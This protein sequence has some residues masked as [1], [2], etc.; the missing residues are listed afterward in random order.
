[1]EDKKQ[2]SVPQHTNVSDSSKENVFAS[3]K[4]ITAWIMIISAVLFALIGLMGIWQLLGEDTGDIMWRAF[5]S[6]LVIAFAS[7]IVNV[8]SRVGESKH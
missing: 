8:A 7:L 3:V 2:D 1:M 5:S 4:H 6:L